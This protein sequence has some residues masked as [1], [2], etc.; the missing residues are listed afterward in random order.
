MCA[1]KAMAADSMN[2]PATGNIQARGASG[3]RRISGGCD[4]ARMTP[5]FSAM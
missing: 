5:K 3:H 2:T 4:A 1:T